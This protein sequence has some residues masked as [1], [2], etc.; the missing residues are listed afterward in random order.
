MTSGVA[1]LPLFMATGNKLTGSAA[2]AGSNGQSSNG[3]ERLL[4]TVQAQNSGK[5]TAVPV[6]TG[7]SA[8]ADLTEPADAPASPDV[9]STFLLSSGMGKSWSQKTTDQDDEDASPASPTTG[10]SDIAAMAQAVL[11]ATSPVQLPVQTIAAPLT[12]RKPGQDGSAAPAL[13]TRLLPAC[14]R[15]R[16]RVPLPLQQRSRSRRCRPD[17]PPR[18]QRMRPSCPRWR[19]WAPTPPLRLTPSRR[20]R[21][22]ERPQP[23]PDQRSIRMTRSEARVRRTLCRRLSRIPLRRPLKPHPRA[24]YPH[25]R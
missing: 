8:S 21:L 14:W 24:R 12:S 22:W 13:G 10:S 16:P 7:T 3:F 6:S 25:L 9:A 23:H 20:L 18:P 19:L 17:R 15:P 11:L 2:P 5:P 1:S 4:A